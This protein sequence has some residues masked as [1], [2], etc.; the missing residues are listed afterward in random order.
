MLTTC[1]KNLKWFKRKRNRCI[2]TSVSTI[3]HC[4]L[5]FCWWCVNQDEICML[6]L[7][8]W[9][10]PGSSCLVSST[11]KIHP[12]LLFIL[13]IF[14]WFLMFG[15]YNYLLVSHKQV[16]YA[17]TCKAATSSVFHEVS[18]SCFL[19]VLIASAQPVAKRQN[20]FLA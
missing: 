11:N 8:G 4:H 3:I 1:R 17:L 14:I 19:F 16:D 12:I 18:F 13:M 20:S 5:S 7:D 2:L 9:D 15:G 10:V 6:M